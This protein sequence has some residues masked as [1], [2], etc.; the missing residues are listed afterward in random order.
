M[1][2]N[3]IKNKVFKLIDCNYT[4]IYKGNRNQVEKFNGVISKCYSRIFLIKLLDGSIKSFSY[5]DII[6]GNLEIL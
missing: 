1:N 5:N 6:I 4:F 3:N 2:I